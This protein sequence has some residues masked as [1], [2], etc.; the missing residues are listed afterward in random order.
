MELWRM[1]PA[2]AGATD[3]AVYFPGSST[4]SSQSHM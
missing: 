3:D 1:G 4:R 2:F